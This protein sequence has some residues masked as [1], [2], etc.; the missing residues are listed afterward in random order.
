MHL[1]V[2]SLLQAITF[3]FSSVCNLVTLVSNSFYIHQSIYSSSCQSP[4]LSYSCLLIKNI[5]IM[6]KHLNQGT[7]TGNFIFKLHACQSGIQRFSRYIKIEP[8][9]DSSIQCN[10][11]MAHSFLEFKLPSVMWWIFPSFL[12]WRVW[13]TADYFSSLCIFCFFIQIHKFLLTL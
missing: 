13:T 5:C 12:Y 3:W 11:N 9:I 1:Y 10:G 4:Y 6:E 8:N 7:T 2:F